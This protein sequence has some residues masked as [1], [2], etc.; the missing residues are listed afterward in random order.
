MRGSIEAG[1]SASK[2]GVAAADKAGLKFFANPNKNG[3]F[4]PVI[5][6]EA[7]LALGFSRENL[8]VLEEGVA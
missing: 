5:G 6:K 1:L 3:D 8:L 2:G 7:S 4:V